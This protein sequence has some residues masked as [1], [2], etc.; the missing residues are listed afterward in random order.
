MLEYF[1]SPPRDFVV[2]MTQSRTDMLVT[3]YSE[4]HMDQTPANQH[5]SSNKHAL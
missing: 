1:E 2:G 5:G 4:F 3:S